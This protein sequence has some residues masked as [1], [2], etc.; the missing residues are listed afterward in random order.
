MADLLS[1]KSQ[2][3]RAS[4]RKP[5]ATAT[6]SL[7]ATLG[8]LKKT[9]NEEGFMI[10]G[11]N[12]IPE[13]KSSIVIP[14]AGIMTVFSTFYGSSIHESDHYLGAVYSRKDLYGS[15][16]LLNEYL[17]GFG[18]GGGFVLLLQGQPESQII[19]NFPWY[20]TAP[21]R[22][23]RIASYYDLLPGGS[24][25]GS[26]YTYPDSWPNITLFPTVNEQ[27]IVLATGLDLIYDDNFLSSSGNEI[28]LSS[29]L[30]NG[31]NVGGRSCFFDQWLSNDRATSVISFPCPSG[32]FLSVSPVTDDWY[33]SQGGVRFYGT[34]V[35]DIDDVW[36]YTRIPFEAILVDPDDIP[37][38]HTGDVMPA[39]L[40]NIIL[41]DETTS[42]RPHCFFSF[43]DEPDRFP[44]VFNTIDITSTLSKYLSGADD[45]YLDSNPA[46]GKWRLSAHWFDLETGES[47]SFASDQFFALLQSK[48]RNLTI[49]G[50]PETTSEWENAV[51]VFRQFFG[52]PNRYFDVPHDTWTFNAGDRNLYT[53]TRYYG[54][55]KIDKLGIYDFPGIYVPQVVID[56]D[57]VRPTI[58]LSGVFVDTEGLPFDRYI[59]VCEKLER[60]VEAE[61]LPQGQREILGIYLGTPLI[62]EPWEP[63]GEFLVEVEDEVWTL[64]HVRIAYH[65]QKEDS[66]EEIMVL[67]IVRRL[68]LDEDEEEQISYYS[69]VLQYNTDTGG[70]W[71]I[72]GKYTVDTIDP[73]FGERWSADLCLFGD[74]VLSVKMKKYISP[75]WAASQSPCGPYSGYYS[76]LP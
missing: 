57:G 51:R 43:S 44:L 30:G 34:V 36:G 8:L 12:V 49:T 64:C 15:D 17:N 5:R 45:D 19:E 47:W 54:S 2:G 7:L 27:V 35:Y 24:F 69:A 11:N 40:R 20:N 25:S 72:A 18:G 6:V 41:T 38:L 23:V 68:Y 42:I 70:D 58:R 65:E 53:W 16:Y 26:T 21:T 56:N 31:S 75:P 48:A 10:Q 28:F 13:L 73:V 63:F 76:G 62:D 39:D 46:E 66:S 33:P 29:H 37:D 52:R 4:R 50:T 55:I 67:G 60:A 59:C 74:S 9:R 1:H 61:D 22:Y 32:S 3:E 14:P 71:S